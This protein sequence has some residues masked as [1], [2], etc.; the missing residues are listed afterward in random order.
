MGGGI[1]ERV[2]PHIFEP[3]FSTK[4]TQNGTGLGLYMT[5]MIIEEHMGGVISVTN[6]MQG[7][8]FKIVLQG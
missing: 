7:A 2:M 6:T 4:T 3:Y 5:K 1:E 8:Q